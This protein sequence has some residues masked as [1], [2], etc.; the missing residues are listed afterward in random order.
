MEDTE[1]DVQAVLGEQLD[2]RDREAVESL[3]DL[4]RPLMF[5]A[6]EQTAATSRWLLASLLAVNGGAIL[7]SLNSAEIG[8]PAERWAILF[9]VGGIVLAL[10]SGLVAMFN[11]QRGIAVAGDMLSAI[12][13]MLQTGAW[14]DIRFE[15][16]QVELKRRGKVAIA[17]GVLSEIAFVVGVIVAAI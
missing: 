3:R 9:W 8:G 2:E 17:V 5:Q 7:A 4:V 1:S 15:A 14:Q 13:K 10:G 16:E 12:T 6:A 11:G